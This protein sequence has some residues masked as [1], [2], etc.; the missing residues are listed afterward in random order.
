MTTVVTFQPGSTESTVSL[1]T[2]EDD[3][4]EALENF[5]VEL[6]NPTAGATIGTN[7]SATVLIADDDG[8]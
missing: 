8:K 2:T 7:R 1:A 5:V 4:N 6:S 3:I